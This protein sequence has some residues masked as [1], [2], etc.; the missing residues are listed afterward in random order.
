M[1]I[2]I[3][4]VGDF[5]IPLRVSSGDVA[6]VKVNPFPQVGDF[7]IPV[8]LAGR[9]QTLIYVEPCDT[10]GDDCFQAMT[11]DG[12]RTLVRLKPG[13]TTPPCDDCTLGY[14]IYPVDIVV[15]GFSGN[16]GC[17]VE[18]PGGDKTKK[19]SCSQMNVSKFNY[20]FG[21]SI[22]Y[23]MDGCDASCIT[24]NGSVQVKV[25]C[26]ATTK[27]WVLEV[28]SS[29]SDGPEY[30]FKNE[31][32]P[33]ECGDLVG[34]YRQLSGSGSATLVSGSPYKCAEDGWTYCCSN[35]TVSVSFEPA[36]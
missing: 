24:N 4:G 17:Y 3:P 9:Q 23:A 34:G 12:K 14:G 8:M 18:V 7:A 22:H 20:T 19:C 21:T 16:S 30:Y 28:I 10:P 36:A 13:E 5:A 26:N 29:V 2:D 15:S 35:G 25:T 11:S 31:D 33:V 27:K 32:F 1:A 6:L